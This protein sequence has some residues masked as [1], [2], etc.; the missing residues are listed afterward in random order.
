MSTEVSRLLSDMLD[1]KE[2]YPSGRIPGHKITVSQTIVLKHYLGIGVNSMSF[3]EIA[4]DLESTPSH[5]HVLCRNGLR[6]VG[7]DITPAKFKERLL[8][9]READAKI[10]K[11][12]IDAERA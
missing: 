11:K 12:I 9:K 5:L 1:L 7:I 2:K 4:E 10:C 3:K 8:S 6:N